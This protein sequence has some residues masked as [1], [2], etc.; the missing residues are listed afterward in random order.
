MRHQDP[1]M[2]DPPTWTTRT[3][4]GRAVQVRKLEPADAAL[5]VDLFDH[6][7]DQ[8]RYQRFNIPLPHVDRNIVWT[9]A[10]RMAN[11]PPGKG[12]AFIALADLDGET[13]APVGGMRYLITAP[14]VAEASIAVRDDCQHDG[15][16]SALLAIMLD[17]ARQRGIQ[18]IL[19]TVQANNSA[20][21]QLLRKSGIPLVRRRTGSVVEIELTLG[22]V[23]PEAA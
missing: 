21:W 13:A 14:G 8:S 22:P 4:S 7:G 10:I 19:A 12:H 17:H 23:L 11:V 1:L 20:V 3:R 16:G 9:E 6:L 15:L 5:L 2:T 18:K